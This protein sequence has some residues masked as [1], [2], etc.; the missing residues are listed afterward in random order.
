[1]SEGFS[2][3][4]LAFLVEAWRRKA[5][6]DGYPYTDET[7]LV[8]MVGKDAKGAPT[9]EVAPASGLL[10]RLPRFPTVTATPGSW[11]SDFRE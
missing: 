5:D 1:M 8:L 10:Q 3:G 6:E 7:R 11:S 9:L 4:L 2:W